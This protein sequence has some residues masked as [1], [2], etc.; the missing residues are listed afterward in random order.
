V[1]DFNRFDPFAEKNNYQLVYEMANDAVF[2]WRVR[3]WEKKGSNGRVKDTTVHGDPAT[4]V[5]AAAEVL[6][7]QPAS[8]EQ[9]CAWANNFHA[10]MYM[11]KD[12]KPDIVAAIVALP[13]Q[14]KDAKVVYQ[15]PERTCNF[16]AIYQTTNEYMTPEEGLKI[17]NLALKQAGMACTGK[18]S[19]KEHSAELVCNVKTEPWPLPK[20]VA[21]E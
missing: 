1:K 5:N 18:Y 19:A 13:A 20:D 2:Q 11:V 14:W 8:F 16:N 4:L 6:K 17:G 12:D 3:D 21:V 10:W 9:F 7:K 15:Q